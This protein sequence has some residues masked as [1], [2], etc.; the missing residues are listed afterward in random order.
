MSAQPLPDIIMLSTAD[1]DNPFWT[2]K[3]HVA[4]TLANMGYR[5][6]YIES[7]GLRPPSVNASDIKRIVKRVVK[8]LSKPKQ[9]HKNIYVFSPLVLP[10][11]NNVV[12]KI[13]N[14]VLFNGLL[15]FWLKALKFNK[16][17]LWTYS[18][19][20]TTLLNL[21]QFDRTIYH[22]V[23]EIKA[24]PGMPA[25]SIEQ[26]EQTLLRDIDI[27]FTTSPA[28]QNTKSISNKQCYFYPN[29]ADFSHFN[30][31]LQPQEIPEDIQGLPGS[32][33]GFIGALSNYKVDMPLLVTLAK[34]RPQDSIVLIGKVGEG[35]PNASVAEFE[36]I[37]NI[38]LLGPK[39]Y[40]QLPQY[41]STFDVALLPCVLNEY[42]ASMFPMKFFEYLAAGKQVVS[43]Q[44]DALQLYENVIYLTSG[45]QSFI[46]AV[47]S[48][49]N[50]AKQQTA[51]EPLINL[52]REHT[53]QTRTKKML[54]KINTMQ[55]ECEE[56]AA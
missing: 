54:E 17:W 15:N 18:P 3:Q 47:E 52:A 16:Q 39:P 9:A 51:S 55:L 42:T 1:W 22:C 19:I 35:Q 56:A 37:N 11:Q 24:Q 45:H 13:L 10:K 48:A 2:N 30:Q 21:E 34:S 43:T 41:L 46:A 14:R 7:T 25:Q 23:D 40:Q 4:L 12:I 6:F 33:I 27:V 32:I 53:Y 44:L 50:A 38:H 29:V 49:I 26:A 36:G 5:I 28:L 31:A 20:T 8:G